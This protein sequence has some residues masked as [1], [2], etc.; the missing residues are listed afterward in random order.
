MAYRGVIVDYISQRDLAILLMLREFRK[1][2]MQ[3]MC[4]IVVHIQKSTN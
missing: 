4:K 1:E 2:T 3:A